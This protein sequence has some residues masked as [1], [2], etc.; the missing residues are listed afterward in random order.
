MKNITLSLAIA[1]LVYACNDGT[2]QSQQ[3]EEISKNAVLEFIPGTYVRPFGEQLSEN[4]NTSGNDTLRITK[5]TESGSETFLIKRSTLIK[6]TLDGQEQPDEPRSANW[7]A[8]FLEA[9]KTLY[10]NNTG[11]VIAFDISNKVLLMDNNK[12]QKIE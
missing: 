4:T 2:R 8:S 11:V 7:T 5:Q 9:D 3:V 1:V 10:V 12:F 6:R